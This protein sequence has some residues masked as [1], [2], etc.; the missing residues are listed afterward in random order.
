MGQEDPRTEAQDP[1]TEVE[2]KKAQQHNKKRNHKRR[3]NVWAPAV[4][5]L[6]AWPEKWATPH[7]PC[8][9]SDQ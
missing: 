4:G 6:A 8:A 3:R 9:A 7:L 5:P 1:R 2:V